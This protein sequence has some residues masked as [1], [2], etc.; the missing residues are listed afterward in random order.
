MRV[1]QDLNNVLHGTWS[2]PLSEAACAA[3]CHFC[4]GFWCPCCF[5]YQQ[6]NKILDITGEPYVCC[7]GSC[8]CCQQTCDGREPWLCLEACCCTSPAILANRYMIQTRFDVQN[9]P[10]DETILGLTA[11]I[12][13]LADCAEICMDRESARHL[14]HVMHLINACICSCMLT[15]Q[16]AELQ[17][18]EEAVQAQPYAGPPQY[19]FVAL[20]PEQQGMVSAAQALRIP[21]QPPVQQPPMQQQQPLHAGLLAGQVQPTAPGGLVAQGRQVML[22]VPPGTAPG[23]PVTFTNPDGTQSQVVVPQG[24]GPGQQFLV[25]C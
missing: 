19:I 14:E 18:V 7:G 9:D 20:P 11:F 16:H 12:N 10:C 25:N 22:T 3:P 2:V 23:Q 6:R 8:I 1:K 4:A 17:R 13:M 15:Q 21:G 24:V 5:A